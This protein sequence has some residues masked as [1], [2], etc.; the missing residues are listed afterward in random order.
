MPS[1][2]KYRHIGLRCPRSMKTTSQ[3]SCSPSNT[4]P[5]T[6]CAD[7]RAHLQHHLSD[8]IYR[9]RLQYKN[10]RSRSIPRLVYDKD[11]TSPDNAILAFGMKKVAR[12]MIFS[13]L[14]TDDAIKHLPLFG[15]L[16]PGTRKQPKSGVALPKMNPLTYALSLKIASL[17]FGILVNA[18]INTQ[19]CAPLGLHGQVCPPAVVLTVSVGQAGN[20]M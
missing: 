15:C 16:S 7:P 8:D 6:R 14:T 12:D 20:A 18:V 1:M 2:H 5:Q 4:L 19:W 17:H 9:C 11:P 10:G 13:D 3:G